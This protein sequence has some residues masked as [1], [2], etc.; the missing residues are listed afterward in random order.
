QPYQVEELPLEHI[1]PD[2][3]NVRRHADSAHI[4]KL[5]Q[6]LIAA[7]ERGEEFY[8]PITVYAVGRSRYR[9]KFGH[10]RYYA[11]QGVVDRLH[12]RVV[13]RPGD[14]QLILDQLDE[15][16]HQEELNDLD[17]GWALRRYKD[18]TNCSLSEL[19]AKVEQLG[20]SRDGVRPGKFWLRFHLDLTRLHDHVQAMI[21]NEQLAPTTAWQL[22]ALPLNKQAEAAGRIVREG[23]TSR[24]VERMLNPGQEPPASGEEEDTLPSGGDLFL[25]ELSSAKKPPA[26]RLQPA[27]PDRDNSSVRTSYE[28]PS[29]RTDLATLD[30]RTRRALERLDQDPWSGQ[31]SSSEK[32]VARDAISLGRYTVQEAIELAERFS[33][34]WPEA[35]ELVQQT[36]VTVRRMLDGANGAL[37]RTAIACLLRI[38]LAKLGQ[39]LS[40]ESAYEQA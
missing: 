8:N 18:A 26:R 1:E 39:R 2:P 16:L 6:S 22:R 13:P 4:H 30:Q 31:A 5:R 38:Y 20:L 19:Q 34:E 32:A 3:R 35:G 21:S 36:M 29:L 23:L 9:I 15:S 7:L 37:P 28:Y 17:T 11:A 12:F 24:D 40:P 33:R 27:D 14:S 25:K 10:R